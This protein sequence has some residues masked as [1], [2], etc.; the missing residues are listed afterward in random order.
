M[1]TMSS[2]IAS[3]VDSHKKN[4][5]AMYLIFFPGF[6]AKAKVRSDKVGGSAFKK[7]GLLMKKQSG[8]LKERRHTEV[9]YALKSIQ[10]D[11]ISPLFLEE[12]QNEI[13][14]L[15]EMVCRHWL[16]DMALGFV[17]SARQID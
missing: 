11:R 16:L 14:I 12:L 7:Q 2:S 13:N 10:L 9:F 1:D 5:P 8:S 6:V 4:V 15:K 3:F 17:F